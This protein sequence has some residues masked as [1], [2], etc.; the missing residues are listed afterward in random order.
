MRN[1]LDDAL[2]IVS[3]S[4]PGPATVE[5]GGNTSCVEVMVGDEEAVVLDAGTKSGRKKCRREQPSQA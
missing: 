4:A 1:R 3:K 2:E 5:Y